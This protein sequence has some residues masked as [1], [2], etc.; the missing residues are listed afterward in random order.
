MSIAYNL[1]K[2]L[3][4]YELEVSQETDYKLVY[5]SDNK[6][7]LISN[8]TLL[9]NNKVSLNTLKD[10]KYR[11]VLNADNEE[12]VTQEIDVVKY[13]QN[14]IINDVVEILCGNCTESVSCSQTLSSYE[15][16]I[17]ESQNIF[18]KILSYQNIYIPKYGVDYLAIFSR[19][20]EGAIALA[21]CD[22]QNSINGI[23]AQ[24]IVTGSST[25]DV[26]MLKTHLFIYWAGLYFL[27]KSLVDPLDT[28]EV[29]FLKDKYQY[30]TVIDCTCDLCFNITDLENVYNE[31]VNLVEINSY[32]L[33]TISEGIDDITNYNYN[34][35]QY[36]EEVMLGGTEITYS[37]IGRVGFLIRNKEQN[38]YKILD[39]LGADITDTVFDYVYQG[40]VSYYLSK[41]YVSFSTIYY[42]FVKNN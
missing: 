2:A 41:E 5:T 31:T 3:D 1:T 6:E 9:A 4:I 28:E 32:Q 10:G 30:S 38:P 8:E 18:N 24:E 27:E 26:R 14:S 36:S 34:L 19:Y 35:V 13:L 33:D 23:V 11:V 40:G 12:E 16:R 7:E 42:K 20:L 39:I 25:F 37:K 22:T 15:R 29:E 21:N 17:L